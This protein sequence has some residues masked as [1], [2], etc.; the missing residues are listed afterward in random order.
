MVHRIKDDTCIVA[1]GY[2]MAA[3]GMKPG[4]EKLYQA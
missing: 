3:Q 2:T 4:L 1:N